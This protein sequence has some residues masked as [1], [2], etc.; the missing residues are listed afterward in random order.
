M[1]PTTTTEPQEWMTL[2]WWKPK[3]LKGRLM[4][5]DREGRTWRKVEPQEWAPKVKKKA[6]PQEWTPKMVEPQE[7][8]HEDGGTPGVDT[9]DGGTTVV[10]AEEN[11]E[12]VESS[13]ARMQYG[14]QI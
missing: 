2:K 13:S 1:A 12:E 8:N 10:D 9:K 14:R 7:W 5:T 4:D 6:E 3:L 11:A